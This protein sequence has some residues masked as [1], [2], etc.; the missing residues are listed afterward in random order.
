MNGMISSKRQ[1]LPPKISTT[2]KRT[3]F[4]WEDDRST[5]N[6]SGNGTVKVGDFFNVTM[7]MRDGKVN[8]FYLPF[9]QCSTS[10][11]NY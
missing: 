5:L 7:D 11:S 8:L 4:L 1:G 2:S 6:E 3:G 10:T 9:T